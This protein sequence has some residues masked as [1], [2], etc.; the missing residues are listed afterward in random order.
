MFSTEKQSRYLGRKE[1][2]ARG[3]QEKFRPWG[4]SERQARPLYGVEAT[5]LWDK[6]PSYGEMDRNGQ[7][8]TES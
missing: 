1:L 6:R 4:I 5:A 7:K 8:W 2:P 3:E